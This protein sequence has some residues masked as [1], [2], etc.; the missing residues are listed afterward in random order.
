MDSNAFRCAQD[1]SVDSNAFRC[2]QDDR[3]DSN[4]LRCA[5]DDNMNRRLSILNFLLNY[6]TISFSLC[7]FLPYFFKIDGLSALCFVCIIISS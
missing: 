5:Q 2:A 6:L 1:D 3:V 4:A 7:I